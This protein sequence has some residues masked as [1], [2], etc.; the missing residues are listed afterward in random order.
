M[1]SSFNKLN[2]TIFESTKNS[3]LL[4]ETELSDIRLSDLQEYGFNFQF[5]DKPEYKGLVLMAIDDTTPVINAIINMV[6]IYNLLNLSHNSIGHTFSI[7]EEDLNNIANE[8]K[9]RHCIIYNAMLLNTYLYT[10]SPSKWS[11]ILK[12]YAQTIGFAS[13]Y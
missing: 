3:T 12:R 6:I 1:Q 4:P 11:Y 7:S 10:L 13:E 9:I 8:I 2:T 5:P